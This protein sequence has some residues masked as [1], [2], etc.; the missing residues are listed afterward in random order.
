MNT[1]VD[2]FEDTFKALDRIAARGTQSNSKT[3]KLVS[4]H[5]STDKGQNLLLLLTWSKSNKPLT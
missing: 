3:G 1:T 2:N 5:K 4:V